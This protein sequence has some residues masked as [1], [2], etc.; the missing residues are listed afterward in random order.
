MDRRA[1]LKGAGSALAIGAPA[2]LK[3]APRPPNIILILADDLGFGDLGCYGS[4]IR[5]PNLDSMANEG[6]R[7]QH[8]SV[9]SPVCSPSR[10]GLLTGRYPVRTGISTVLT[11]Q[12]TYGLPDTE[13]TIAQLL[14][15]AGYKTMCV[16]KWHLG[17]T[18]QYS[19][20]KH[21]FDDFYGMLCSND[22][23]P[24]MVMYGS[25]VIE[26]RA[27]L[28]TLT[29]RYTEQAVNFIRRSKDSPFFLYMPHTAPHV[30]LVP[31]PAFRGKSGLGPYGDVVQEM[32]WSVGQVLQ[33][34]QV[35]GLA[36]N[37]L[38]LFTSDNGP[39]FQGSPG[40]LRGRKGDTFE[41]GVREPFIARFPGRI[42]AG[43]TIDAFASALDILPTIAGLTQTAPPNA[44][45]GV[46]IWPLL[47]GDK[48]QVERPPFLYFD[49]WHL[50]CAR[51]GQWKIHLSRYSSPSWAP[52]P[53]S[54][55]QSLPLLLPEL[56]D[57]QSDPGEDY[58]CSGDNP[59]LVADLRT[60]VQAML[61]SFPDP[62]LAAWNDTQKA[63]VYP[64]ASG[65]LPVPNP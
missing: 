32:D 9:A 22:Q 15:Q 6:V 48:A 59:D 4:R 13:A 7:F 19:P 33:E 47:T 46:D 5:T 34:L 36:D 17:S 51:M 64:N 54:G 21:G 25:E 23:F 11:P 63:A 28:E 37:T 43:K 24:T 35:N 49:G 41:G 52:T 39:W 61:P 44:L 58:D 57:L 10:A 12:D 29:Q 60:R 53:A 56:Y 31:S 2:V 50:Q 16:G 26:Q 30:P 38:V 8:F 45:D 3:S 55:R 20:M 1:F 14:K 40:P 18:A 27:K 65:A 62:V 42:P